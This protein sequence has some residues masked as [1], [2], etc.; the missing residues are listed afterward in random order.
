MTD[1]SKIRELVALGAAGALAEDES[2]EVRRH[3]AECDSCRR[4]FDAWSSYAG[5][6]KTLPQP[7]VPAHLIARTQA[8]IL[9]EHAG[10]RV[11]SSGI[12]LFAALAAFSWLFTYSGWLVAR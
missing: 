4:E 5:G 2:L 8:R 10:A 6:L 1:H 12:P 9:R 7:V 3:L 11:E